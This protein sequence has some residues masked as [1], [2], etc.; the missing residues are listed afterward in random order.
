MIFDTSFKFR[1]LFFFLQAKLRCYDYF[2]RFRPF[3]APFS[4]FWKNAFFQNL[5]QEA[6]NVRCLA[7]HLLFCCFSCWR[8]IFL[9]P[10]LRR[11]RLSKILAL[12]STDVLRCR[13]R[14]FLFFATTVE[15]KVR[16]PIAF[17]SHLSMLKETQLRRN[18]FWGLFL[19][20]FRSKQI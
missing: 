11:K 3:S 8:F 6:R 2:S 20:C 10:L 14:S 9:L 17:S 4:K 7:R 5:K 12:A 1:K 16:Q 15:V 13:G 19:D 18:F